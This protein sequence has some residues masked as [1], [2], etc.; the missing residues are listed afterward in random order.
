MPDPVMIP[1]RLDINNLNNKATGSISLADI[2]EMSIPEFIQFQDRIVGLNKYRRYDTALYKN[3][4]AITPSHT[5]AMFTL[6]VGENDQWAN[7]PTDT[8]KKTDV[9]TNMPV[10]GRWQPGEVAII[11]QI[12][13]VV[14]F[15]AGKP[16]TSADGIVSQPAV[17]FATNID[18][19]ELQDVADRQFKIQ[20]L[21]GNKNVVAEGRLG[22]FPQKTGK[23]GSGGSSAT[24]TSMFSQ[25]M[26]FGDTNILVKPQVIEG[27][28]DWQI[29]LQPL[30][31]SLDM[32]T[33]ARDIRVE[34]RLSTWEFLRYY[35]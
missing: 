19:F 22:D 18:V 3:S 7:D 12:E 8:I 16:T 11:W 29:S 27:G 30:A 28:E 2:R 24:A 1:Y 32:S 6:G 21:R 26:G 34:L 33:A 5:A 10:H 14:G 20:M 31:P 15:N 4:I 13:A 9:H 35:A 25:N 17:A 23:S